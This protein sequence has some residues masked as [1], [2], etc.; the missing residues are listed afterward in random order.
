MNR[1]LNKTVFETIRN[2]FSDTGILEYPLQL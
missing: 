1:K 2:A